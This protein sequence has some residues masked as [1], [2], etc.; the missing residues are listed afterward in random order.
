MKQVR[1]CTVDICV[2]LS[3]SKQ[4]LMVGVIMDHC[5][6]DYTALPIE[7][8]RLPPLRRR[9]EKNNNKMTYYSISSWIEEQALWRCGTTVVA[10]K[11]SAHP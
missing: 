5:V 8:N 11:K 10:I 9:L 7:T 1:P 6:V 3:Q 4:S 2:T